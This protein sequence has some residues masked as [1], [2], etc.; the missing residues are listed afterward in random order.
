MANNDRKVL[1]RR[2]HKCVAQ[3]ERNEA[4]LLILKN[5]IDSMRLV[6]ASLFDSLGSKEYSNWCYDNGYKIQAK[7]IETGTMKMCAVTR[8]ATTAQAS[9][10][11]CQ[12]QPEISTITVDMTTLNYR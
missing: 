2:I 12:Q 9:D 5:A 3:A 10:Q 1:L 4:S 7:Q 8:L 6:I 11:C